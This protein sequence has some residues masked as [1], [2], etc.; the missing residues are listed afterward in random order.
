MKCV[1]G[2]VKNVGADDLGSPMLVLSKYGR[3]VKNNILIMNN[4]Y[5]DIKAVNFVIM[6]NHLQYID[7]NPE[8]WLL[9][10]DEYY[11]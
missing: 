10:K 7:E 2:T 1:L 3:V 4:I 9:G 8:K 6:P 11:V 5:S